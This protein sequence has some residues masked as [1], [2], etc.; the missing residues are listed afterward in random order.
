MTRPAD[1]TASLVMQA[2]STRVL[3]TGASGLAG[4]A[5]VERLL[6][7]GYDV[8]ATYRRTPPSVDGATW[9][10]VDLQRAPAVRSLWQEIEPALVINSV[11]TDEPKRMWVGNVTTTR[12]IAAATAA[13]G[14]RLTHLSSDLVFPGSKT[15]RYREGDERL[16]ID[17]Y[18]K[19]RIVAEDEVARVDDLL[20]VRTSLLYNGATP[21]R[22]EQRVIDEVRSPTRWRF[23]VDEFR[24]PTQVDDVA[25]S[26]VE[27]SAQRATGVFHATANEIVSRFAFA[28]MVAAKFGEDPTAVLGASVGDVSVPRAPHV[29]LDSSKLFTA[30]D[31]RPRDISEVLAR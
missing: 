11:Y 16:G 8:H 30:L 9:H 23:F 6:H 20:I 31:W 25:R 19:A 24:C 13:V 10:H 18:G 17:P 26:V 2:T 29:A 14:A 28:Q 12:N 15:E 5:I 27:L 1:D 7:D 22:H 21:A 3:V 4:T